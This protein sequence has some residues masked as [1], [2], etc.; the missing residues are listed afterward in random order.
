MLDMTSNNE[1]IDSSLLRRWK[2]KVASDKELN[3][4]VH[5]EALRLLCGVQLFVEER[6]KQLIED[7]LS[8]AVFI[9]PN[10]ERPLY[11]S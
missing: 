1:R 2:R 7:V 4:S 9:Q 11:V 3:S 5:K 8:E 6:Q 10:N